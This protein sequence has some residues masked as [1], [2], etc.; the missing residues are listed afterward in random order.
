MAGGSSV[1]VCVRGVEVGVGEGV[2]GGSSLCMAGW[3]G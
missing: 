3:G 1:C 2:E